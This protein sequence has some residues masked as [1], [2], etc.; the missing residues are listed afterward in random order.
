MSHSHSHSSFSAK[1]V[2]SASLEHLGFLAETISFLLIINENKERFNNPLYLVFIGLMMLS[3]L[4]HH[5]FN[6]T[7]L[8]IID[9]LNEHEVAELG[10]SVKWIQQTKMEDVLRIAIFLMFSVISGA[11]TYIIIV[12]IEAYSITE[13]LDLSL[14]TKF[15]TTA[16]LTLS[17]FMLLW[18]IGGIVTDWKTYFKPKKVAS[19]KLISFPRP[20]PNSLVVSFVSDVLGFFV[21]IGLFMMLALEK[22]WVMNFIGVFALLY[23]VVIMLRLLKHLS[24]KLKTKPSRYLVYTV[25]V[26][27][28]SFVGLNSVIYMYYKATRP[29]RDGLLAKIKHGEPLVIAMEEDSKPMYYM[30]HDSS[31]GKYVASGFGYAFAER[32]AKNMNVDFKILTARFND[33]PERLYEGEADII[34]AGETDE[35]RNCD[36]TEPFIDTIGLCLI[37]RKQDSAKYAN[38]EN[39]KDKK[40]AV[41]RG[42]HTALEWA[43]D[44]FPEAEIDASMTESGWLNH[45]NKHHWDAVVYEYMYA[46][47]EIN[48]LTEEGVKDNLC[49]P[50]KTL[51]GS[52]RHFKIIVPAKN[53]DLVQELNRHIE[54]IKHTPF[55]DS[56]MRKYI[57]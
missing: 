32:L 50:I 11:I 40:I 35:I 47:D 24:V 2:V 41:F 14:F 25:I 42:A 16:Y 18:H 57:W 8:E 48:D 7:N 6:M 10:Y 5:F 52:V 1:R 56:L 33:L 39:L 36:E 19:D 29:K 46:K 9:E 51:P 31:C 38:L 45:F 55:Y 43:K 3:V 49:I 28:L 21:W 26:L 44:H 17:F 30:E 13:S 34:I 23:V 4:F 27:G 54:E 20:F 53:K 37:V 12:G 15:Y 22:W